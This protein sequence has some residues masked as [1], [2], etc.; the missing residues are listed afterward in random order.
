MGLGDFLLSAV[1]VR[2]R[3]GDVPPQARCPGEPQPSRPAAAWRIPCPLIAQLHCVLL[4]P[5]AGGHVR[6][7][8]VPLCCLL[9]ASSASA[10]LQTNKQEALASPETAAICHLILDTC[11]ELP[12]WHPRLGPHHAVGVLLRCAAEQPRLAPKV[13]AAFHLTVDAFSVADQVALL[14]AISGLLDASATSAAGVALLLHFGPPVQRHFH[15]EAVLEDLVRAEERGGGVPGWLAVVGRLSKWLSKGLK[16]G[17]CSSLAPAGRALSLH[18][19]AGTPEEPAVHRPCPV[20]PPHVPARP[21][22]AEQS[23]PGGDPLC[24][25]AGQPRHAGDAGTGAVLC[26]AAAGRP[27]HGTAA[28]RC[29]LWRAS[30]GLVAGT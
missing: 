1:E 7:P 2:Q 13:A 22:G 3:T 4:Q 9:N 26:C 15:V 8:R 18:A 10:P 30:S 29:R 11:S 24:A 5:Y 28:A 27:Q 23:R 19:D 21:A 16:G 17:S 12:S 6:V 14:D 25:A 20:S